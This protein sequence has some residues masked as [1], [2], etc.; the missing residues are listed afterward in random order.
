MRALVVC[1]VKSVAFEYQ[2]GTTTNQSSNFAAAFRT[3][4]KRFVGDL[5]EFLESVSTIITFVLV[6]RHDAVKESQGQEARM[7]APP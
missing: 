4:A 3:L 5:L 2:S 6:C 7:P 1:D